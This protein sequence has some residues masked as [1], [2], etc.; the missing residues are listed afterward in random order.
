MFDRF[1]KRIAG[2]GAAPANNERDTS[3]PVSAGG[4]GR[5][6]TPVAGSPTDD[7][8]APSSTVPSSGFGRRPAATGQAEQ[9]PGGGHDAVQGSALTAEAMNE[10]VSKEIID[11]LLL[12]L[13]DERGVHCETLLTALG[14][15]AG[16]AA[17]QSVWATAL[18]AG[19]PPQKAFMVMRTTTGESFYYSEAVNQLLLS[20][21]GAPSLWGFMKSIAERA[22]ATQL[23][24]PRDYF[25]HTSS[26]IGSDVFG[27]PRMP[28]GHMPRVMPRD[29]LNRHW[30]E[31]RSLL[32]PVKAALWPVPLY[33]AIIRAMVMMQQACR[34]EF[35][36]H[37]VMESAVPMSKVDPATVPKIMSSY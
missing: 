30:S 27:I 24:D 25:R 34:L 20:T 18:E 8:P 2:E 16:F 10:D 19:V 3:S 35:A 7:M 15:L 28:E 21:K 17:Q 31:T 29:A 11:R 22:G 6:Q 13:R 9:K 14:A 36:C 23:P 33:L 1:K 4:F 12:E 26:V 5:R 37:I 32:E